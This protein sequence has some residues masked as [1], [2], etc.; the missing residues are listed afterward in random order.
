MN[1]FKKILYVLS[2]PIS[3]PQPSLIRAMSLAKNNQAELTVLF[4]LPKL[5][6]R[7]SNISEQALKEKILAQ[8]QAHLDQLIASSNKDVTI[9]FDFLVGKK[10]LEIIRSVALNN[11][12]LVVKDT[13]DVSWLDR[14]IGSDD[15]H[16]LRK[17]PCPVWLMKNEV[18]D[19]YDQ[20]IAAVDF[21]TNSGD[22]CND[23]LN[24]TITTLASSLALSGFASLHIVNAYDVPEA[25]YISLWAD[26][27]EAIK[28]KL[29]DAEY[30][31]R[32]HKMNMLLAKLKDTIGEESYKYLSP[33][34]HLIQ[35][36]PGRELP[37]LAEEIKADLVV[38]GTVART[39]IAGV[40]IGN[41]AET[42]LTQLKSSVL[43]I[44]PSGF[45]SPAHPN[46][47]V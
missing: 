15:M 5:P 30:Q 24:D 13:D 26:Q 41:T 17:C 32:L 46:K 21:D 25:G 34:P 42:L 23:E 1:R 8:E 4:I 39:G 38:M 10:H 18:Q 43:A 20:I 27:P 44:K 9:K 31:V 29:F 40:V 14:F 35:G 45:V 7:E 33:I 19:S 6:P 3:E 12:D 16:L 22:S 28:A 36:T 37:K 2:D 11:F 47:N